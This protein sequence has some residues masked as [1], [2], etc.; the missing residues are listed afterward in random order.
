MR[1][2]Y[3]EFNDK[4]EKHISSKKSFFTK[5]YNALKQRMTNVKCDGLTN[6]ELP[7]ATALEEF[8][9]IKSRGTG[10]TFQKSPDQHILFITDGRPTAG[11]RYVVR[12]LH[13]A[14]K[15]GVAIHTVFI[16]YSTCPKVL[17][18]LSGETD[19][20][21]Y[22]AF[23]NTSSRKITVQERDSGLDL[24][25]K[26]LNLDIG[27]LNMMAKMPAVFQRYLDESG[28]YGDDNL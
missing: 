17:D 11:D 8:V 24:P 15:M 27:K 4:V 14:K 2:G 6:Y 10:M 7:L 18:K 16:G 22:S 23:L 13:N 1:V 25:G 20:L 12:E 21:K 19:G 3:L 9:R 28:V 26:N 5:D